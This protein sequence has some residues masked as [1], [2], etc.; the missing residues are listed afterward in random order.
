MVER[1]DC[2]KMLYVKGKV[3]WDFG[4]GYF[5]VIEVN[6]NVAW[7]KERT[8]CKLETLD[9]LNHKNIKTKKNKY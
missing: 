8:C 1:N 2:R 9:P 3:L 4:F 7:C 6:E 5:K